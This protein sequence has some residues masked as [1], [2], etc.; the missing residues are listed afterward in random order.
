MINHQKATM[1]G[2]LIQLDHIKINDV[3]ARSKA[4]WQSHSGAMFGLDARIALAIFAALSVIT[5]AAMFKVRQDVEATALLAEMQEI[6]K[7]WEQYYLDTGVSLPLYGASEIS[8]TIGYLVKNVANISGWRGPYINHQ[9]K[10]DDGLQLNSGK[11]AILEAH[12]DETWGGGVNPNI[13]AKCTTGKKCFINMN[14]YVFEDDVLAKKIDE[15]VDSGDG[16]DKGK[17]R[18]YYFTN[19][20]GY[21]LQYAPIKNPND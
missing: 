2:K 15:K 13:S 6:G 7:A 11:G 19:G 20:Y 17:F 21:Y 9:Y 3:I 5:G 1:F 4:T 8:L 16:A 14:F 12:T 10:S 18:W